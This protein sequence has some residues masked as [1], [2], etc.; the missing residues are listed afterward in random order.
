MCYSDVT[1]FLQKLE[2]GA[3]AGATPDFNTQHKCVNFDKI[4][5]WAKANKAKIA[6]DQGKGGTQSNDEHG[7]DH[8]S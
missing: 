3:D 5:N 7:H 1:P 2:T 8:A 6:K 4:Q